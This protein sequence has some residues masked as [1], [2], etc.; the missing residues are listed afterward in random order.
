[1]T[2]K[3]PNYS[4]ELTA[5]IV[6]EYEKGETDEERLQILENL[7]SKHAKPVRS[8]RAKLVREGVYVAKTYKTKTGA[9]PI[10]KETLVGAIAAAMGEPAD[11]LSGLEKATKKALALIFEAVKPEPEKSEKA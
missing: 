5:T 7:S 2:E 8:L 3:T 11:A 9:R 10:T 6:A 1:M 4:P